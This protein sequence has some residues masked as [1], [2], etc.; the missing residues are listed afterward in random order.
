M[1]A[2]ARI[3]LVLSCALVAPH[4]ASAQGTAPAQGVT[5]PLP[6]PDPDTRPPAP[7]PGTL[8]DGRQRQDPGGGAA[9]TAPDTTAKTPLPLPG[10][11]NPTK[12]D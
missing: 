9:N 1:A 3:M 8:S 2:P 4:F 11:T 5:R 6:Q 10:Q 12:M 7:T